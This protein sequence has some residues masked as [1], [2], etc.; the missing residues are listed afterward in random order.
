[1]RSI[2]DVK[3]V[4]LRHFVLVL[5]VFVLGSAAAIEVPRLMKIGALKRKAEEYRAQALAVKKDGPSAEELAVWKR[6]VPEASLS[7]PAGFVV[8]LRQIARDAQC[9]LGNSGDTAATEVEAGLGLS[10]IESTAKLKGSYEGVLR[11]FTLLRREQRVVA[12]TK[13]NVSVSEYPKLQADLTIRRYV[14]RGAPAAGVQ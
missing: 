1:M 14:R 4:L 6:E 5:A 9:E 8:T 3:G 10:S 13:A 7:E 11:F 12:I 2:D